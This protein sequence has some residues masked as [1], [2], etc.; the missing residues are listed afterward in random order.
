M[1]RTNLDETRDILLCPQGTMPAPSDG[2]WIK[3][4]YGSIR[5]NYWD[6]KTYGI[7]GLPGPAKIRLLK[8]LAVKYLIQRT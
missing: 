6:T 5:L 1:R 8:D 4:N 2:I 3:K 7:D